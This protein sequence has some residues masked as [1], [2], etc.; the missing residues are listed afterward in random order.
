VTITAQAPCF[1]KHVRFI[2]AGS[3]ADG[4][5]ISFFLPNLERAGS[6]D[7][8][9]SRIVPS[10]KRM[11]AGNSRRVAWIITCGNYGHDWPQLGFVASD[12]DTMLATLRNAG[13]HVLISSDRSHSDLM[14]DASAF[15]AIL[16]RTTPEI[17]LVYMSGHGM[18]LGGSNYF[19][20]AD[21][22]DSATI[23]AHDLLPIARIADDLRPLADKGDCAI[24]LVD[25][26]RSESG[27]HAQPLTAEIYQTVLVNHS[28]GPGMT[29]FDS[30]QGTSAWT[31][32]FT[33]V[34]NSFPDAEILQIIAYANRYTRWKS[35]ASTRG[36]SPVL[37]GATPTISPTFSA[38]KASS[39]SGVLPRLSTFSS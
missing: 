8:S 9:T 24:V 23:T 19:V 1:P 4:S 33:L 20:P 21:A 22:P 7:S 34:A 30:E 3:L 27:T 18:A 13:Y 14:A 38:W 32:Q 16:T 26:C 2:Q 17:A 12:R 5:E 15:R 11:E 35:E 39:T 10:M 37:Y 31:E 29:S 36:Q 6:C 28:A 25:A